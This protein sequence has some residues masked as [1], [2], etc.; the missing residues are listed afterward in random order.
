MALFHSVPQSD[1]TSLFRLLDDYDTHRS[2][3]K[4]GAL[5]S[6]QPRFDIHEAGDAYHLH[7]ELPG[8]EQ[9]DID[10]SFSDPQ[11]IVIK[12]RTERSYKSSNGKQYQA[13]VADDTEDSSTQVAKQDSNRQG[14]KNNGTDSHFWVMERTVG[15]FHRSFS[16]PSP[17]DQDK[18]T[19]SLKNGILSVVVP[20]AQ[21]AAAKR[22]QI[23]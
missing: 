23:Q 15:E 5:R 7:G 19:A 10:L 13:S 20:K 6:F 8:I 11:S 16:F 9:K 2:G 22:I 4:G 12:G 18:V 17:V 21:P 3:S 14:Q 1:F